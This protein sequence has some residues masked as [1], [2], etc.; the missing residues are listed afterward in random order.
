[1]INIEIKLTGIDK[2]TA[3]LKPE[4]FKKAM[5][6]TLNRA[7]VTIKKNIVREVR[8][9]YNPKASALKIKLIE[10]KANDSKLLWSL[11][12]PDGKHLNIM[13]F[14]GTRVVSGGLSASTKKGSRFVLKHSF[15]GNNGRTVFERIKGTKMTTKTTKYSH[16]KNG[17]RKKREKIKA[18]VGLSPSQMIEEGLKN[19]I[20]KETEKTI[21][22]N[23]KRNLDFYFSKLK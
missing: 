21:P 15:I 4:I 3:K 20:M 1:M 6:R 12:V 2:L 17:E 19:K 8:R 18:V 13:S 16:Y 10:R 7:G 11:N 14:N 23:F 22:G 5:V 9:N